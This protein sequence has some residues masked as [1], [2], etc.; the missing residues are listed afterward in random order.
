MQ[1]PKMF[2]L[3]ETLDFEKSSLAFET[4]KQASLFATR[5][6]DTT[7]LSFDFNGF[8]PLLRSEIY[9]QTSLD[10]RV[11]IRN[12]HEDLAGYSRPTLIKKEMPVFDVAI[13]EEQGHIDKVSDRVYEIKSRGKVVKR[14]VLG[15]T[16]TLAQIQYMEDPFRCYRED[17]NPWGKLKRKTY[18]GATMDDRRQEIYY[19][20]KGKAYMSVWYDRFTGEFDR[21][22]LLNDKGMI[23]KEFSDSNAM[24]KANWLK[25]VLE[26]TE[27]PVTVS[28]SRET[29]EI[30]RELEM[31]DVAKIMRLNNL[32][33]TGDGELN[34]DLAIQDFLE[35]DGFF[36]HS[37]VEKKELGKKYGNEEKMYVVPHCP[38]ENR[39]LF[40]LFK[41][42]KKDK[43]LAVA[44]MRQSRKT[45]YRLIMA[46]FQLVHMQYPDMRLHLHGR[47]SDESYFRKLQKELGLH[48]VTDFSKM[49]TQE[50][51]V[52]EPA[53][54]SIILSNRGEGILPAMESM[55][56][57]TPV[58][59]VCSKNGNLHL[60]IVEDG[61]T[62]FIMDSNNFQALADKMIYMFSN[63]SN[64]FV[65]GEKARRHI[66]RNYNE[67]QCAK[68]WEA[69]IED[70]VGDK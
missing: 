25:K 21:A 31:K 42:R 49:I 37:E 66:K 48:G 38:K 29:D 2:F 4:I 54:F 18:I 10:K 43:R 13:F 32:T 27:R 52:C 8:Y 19:N 3:A 33:K 51:R 6:F 5:G 41:R 62:G 22:H 24:L 35:F 46:A 57:E 14:I 55:S 20:K 9:L 34:D 53:L 36:L 7:L 47:E 40:R 58:I 70:I 26:S 59:G 44:L 1:K 15:K 56:V 45:D 67:D 23:V 61:Q 17:Y 69:F 28:N 64:C 60:G 11:A 30:L 12:M 63:P 65:M 68:K 16:G 39:R 50:S